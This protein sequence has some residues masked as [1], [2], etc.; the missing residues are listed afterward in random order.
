MGLFPPTA[1]KEAI[2]RSEKRWTTL[3]ETTSD[4]AFSV[5]QDGIIQFVHSDKTDWVPAAKAGSNLYDYLLPDDH[6]VFSTCLE[7]VFETAGPRGCEVRIRIPGGGVRNWS[8]RL[9]L[10]GEV[11]TAFEAL[12]V[13]R[14]ISKSEDGLGQQSLEQRMES[15]SRFARSI[16]H[17][18]NNFLTVTS[19]HS[20]L[21][22]KRIGELDPLRKDVEKIKKA[23]DEA[24]LL[25]AQLALVNTRSGP[26]PKGVDLNPLV[27]RCEGALKD[28]LGS[29]I[30]LE[31]ELAPNVGQVALDPGDFEQVLMGLALNAREAMPQGGLLLVETGMASGIREIAAADPEARQVELTVSDNGCGMDEETL[32]RLFE[33]LFTT[34]GKGKGSGLGLSVAYGIVKRSDGGITVQ[35]RI[36]EGSTFRIYLPQVGSASPVDVESKSIRAFFSPSSS[37]VRVPYSR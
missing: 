5:A 13:A 19:I 22:L 11:P 21:L 16:V 17:D 14:E 8:F 30:R 18:F 31:T 20:Q 27:A 1:L 23:G 37:G 3:L 28:L 7:R 9:G 12:V 2:E 29:D 6:Q 15:L 4:S 24:S 25:T 26:R 34:K 33:P 32:E 36:G 35:S 10:M